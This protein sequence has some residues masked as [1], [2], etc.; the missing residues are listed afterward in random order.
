M[1]KLPLSVIVLLITMTLFP[2]YFPGNWGKAQGTV[3]QTAVETLNPSSEKMGQSMFI[4]YLGVE[5]VVYYLDLEHANI[6]FYDQDQSGNPIR[7][8]HHLKRYLGSHSRTLIFAT[9]GGIFRKDGT[10]EGLFI[11][12]GITRYDINMRSGSGNFYLKP[13][14]VF[15]INKFNFPHILDSETYN[16]HFVIQPSDLIL[17]AIQSGPLLLHKGLINT[18]FDPS[19][20][21]LFIRSGV[22]TFETEE[23]KTIAVFVLSRSPVRFYDFALFFKHKLGCKRALYL[24]G[25]ISE[26]YLP[27]LEL[28]HTRNEFGV[29]IGVTQ[30]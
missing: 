29:M 22:G 20:Q 14:G 30:K 10:P 21:N 9:N 28:L 18:Q 25:S 11:R 13:N 3:E 19:S 17:H 15:Y 5:Y 8:I 7:T 2:F 16:K 24:D 12:Q 1:K 26:M 27:G 23:K 6:D 4:T